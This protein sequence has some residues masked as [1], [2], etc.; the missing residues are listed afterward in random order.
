M[1]AVRDYTTE[2]P[3]GV[4]L[5]TLGKADTEGL[6]SVQ[7]SVLAYHAV[8]NRLHESKT[9]SRWTVIGDIPA[10]PRQVGSGFA[11]FARTFLVIVNPTAQS[12]LAAR[13]VARVAANLPDA[14]VLFVASQ[15]QGARDVKHVEK[16]LGT[17]TIGAVPRDQAVSDAERH[18]TALLDFDQGSPAVRAIEQIADALI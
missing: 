14:L 13:R 16:L 2:A 9:L 8:V 5:L 17:S 10:G 15:V 3:D 18:G 7:G 6:A 12:A 1:R 4:R 11:G